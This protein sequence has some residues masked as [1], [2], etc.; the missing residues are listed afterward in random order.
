MNCNCE[1]FRILEMQVGSHLYGTNT[2]ESDTDYSGVFIAPKRFYIGLDQV[3]EVNL[4]TVSKKEN[5]RNDKDAIDRKLYEFRKFINLA[6]GNNPNVIEML[7]VNQENVVY[8]NEFGQMLREN[9]HLFPHQ[10]C[11]Q[12]FIGYAKSQKMKMF[13]K[14]D[15]MEAIVSAIEFFQS[16][17]DHPNRNYVVQYKKD[18]MGNV[19]KAKDTGQHI[20]V[21]DM[22]LQKNDTVKQALR[23]LEDRRAKFSGRYDDFVSKVGYDTKFA[24]HLIRLLLEGIELLRTGN[25]VFPL[26]EANLILDIKQ[27]KYTIEEVMELATDLENSIEMTKENAV[28]PAR[29][30]YNEIENFLIK[31]VEEHWDYMRQAHGVII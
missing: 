6:M 1:Q 8:E 17:E 14:R 21:G 2:P 12:K 31:T 3:Q 13:V 11:L 19:E 26:R 9:A 23:K 20:Q 25:I 7:F 16:V 15:N 30:R 10:G 22:H 24:S 18:L 28:V 5:G 29:P 4:S 27:G